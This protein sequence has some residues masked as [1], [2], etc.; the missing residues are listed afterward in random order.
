MTPREQISA[1][2]WRLLRSMWV[3]ALGG[4]PLS[5]TDAEANALIDPHTERMLEHQRVLMHT[6]DHARAQGLE[7]MHRKL[8]QSEG[9]DHEML[10]Q[11]VAWAANWD[12]DHGDPT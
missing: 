5:M 3:R 4:D 8:H 7:A 2:V 1:T 9:I 11:A 6:I 12:G 10:D